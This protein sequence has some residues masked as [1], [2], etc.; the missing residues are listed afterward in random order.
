MCVCV[1]EREKERETE[2]KKGESDK[3]R[4]KGLNRI[5]IIVFLKV[6]FFL[7]HGSFIIPGIVDWNSNYIN[8]SLY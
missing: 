4:E 1:C 5:Q 7:F 8:D 6:F 3:E 2:E